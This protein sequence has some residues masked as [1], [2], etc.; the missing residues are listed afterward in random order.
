V[1]VRSRAPLLL[2]LAAVV[3]VVV[4]GG[5]AASRFP[6]GYDW[7]YTVVSHLAS[8]T[9]NPDGGRWMA[10]S[11][12]LAL[13]G[14]F[15]L[16]LSVLGRKG[17]EALALAT[18]LGFYAGMLG[19]YVRRIRRSPAFFAPA[20]LIVLPLLGVGVTQ[21]SL[22]LGQGT[23]GWV[24]PGWRELG[25]PLWLSFAFWQWLAMGFLGLGLGT[26]V[27]GSGSPGPHREP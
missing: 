25:V 11:L 26:L 22:Y 27:L 24:N 9:R 10:G 6:G 20:L 12:L 17:H 1:V 18:F 15:G 2:Y 5:V 23:L 16:D 13:E 19:L 4:G 8:T 7:V 21:L 3:S 14:L